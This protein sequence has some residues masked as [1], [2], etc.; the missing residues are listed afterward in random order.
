MQHKGAPSKRK[1][2]LPPVPTWTCPHCSF[3]HTPANLMR[4]DG[5][6]FRCQQCGRD[7]A[8]KPSTSSE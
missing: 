2:K 1:T 5:E 7:F 4:I 3:V 8:A 6:K